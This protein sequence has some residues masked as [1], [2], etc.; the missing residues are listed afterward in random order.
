MVVVAFYPSSMVVG[1]LS[2]GSM[3]VVAFY[4]SS[5]VV[6][7]LSCGSMVV[8]VVAFDPSSM[9]VPLDHSMV[10]VA[11]GVSLVPSMVVV[12]YGG[13]LVPSMV[14]S[15][16]H[17]MV[18][19]VVACDDAYDPNGATLVVVVVAF[20]PSSMVVP[21]DHSMVVVACGVSLDPSMVEEEEVVV[22]FDPR[23]VVVVAYGD[24]LDHSMVLSL[25]A[26]GRSMVEGNPNRIVFDGSA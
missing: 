19:V 12:A 24:A 8:V 9:V 17:S 16:D 26:L 15:L 7:I 21:L 18:E 1:I 3:V 2:C 5:M 13:A 14:V 23:M 11:C 10:V 20:D 6:G 4:P 22:A 25:D